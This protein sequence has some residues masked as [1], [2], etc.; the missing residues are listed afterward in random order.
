[1][2]KGY[3]VAVGKESK[4]DGVF[5][6]ATSNTFLKLDLMTCSWYGYEDNFGTKEEKYLIKYIESIIGKLKEKYCEVY[7]LRNYK[8][9]KIYAFDDGR[10]TEL[11]FV[12]FL[13][14]NGDDGQFDNIQIFI[15]PRGEH[16]RRTDDWKMKFQMRIHDDAILNFQTASDKFE[17]WGVPF[18]TRNL[19]NEF[20][21]A[22]TKNFLKSIT[23]LDCGEPFI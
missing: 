4:E 21:D 3:K 23:A 6:N 11:D 7:L 16:L 14:K 19:E 10:A 17:I 18:Y 12:L 5:M 13:R 1:M 22:M 9:F 20:A 15:E 8:D 2:N